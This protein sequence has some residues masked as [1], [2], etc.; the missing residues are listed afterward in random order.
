M[1][2]GL[3]PRILDT[4]TLAGFKQV[5]F[6]GYA[7]NPHSKRSLAQGEATKL[8]AAIRNLRHTAKTEEGHKCAVACT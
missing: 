2:S 6:V 4:S 3:P 1:A 8:V 5:D 7:T